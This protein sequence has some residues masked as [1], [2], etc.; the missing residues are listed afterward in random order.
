MV[1]P[2][3]DSHGAPLRSSSDRFRQHLESRRA[4]R[5]DRDP[6]GLGSWLVQRGLLVAGPHATISTARSMRLREALRSM[7]LA[8]N[9][10]R[11][12]RTRK[13]TRAPRARGQLAWHFAPPAAPTWSRARAARRALARS[14]YRS[15]NPLRTARGGASRRAAPPTACGLSMTARATARGSGATW[16]CAATAQRCARIAAGR[17]RARADTRSDEA[18]PLRCARCYGDR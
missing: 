8:N 1:T 7:M 11:P 10:V 3:S 15:P 5:R 12:T 13:P 18:P 17:R 9:G 4:D 14:W 6:G 2:Q 16:P